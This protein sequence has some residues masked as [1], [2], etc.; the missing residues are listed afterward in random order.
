MI[1]VLTVALSGI[2]SLLLPG[3][4]TAHSRF[5]IPLCID[6][7]STCK[8]RKGSSLAAL[9]SQAAL[10]VWDKVP[11]NDKASFDALD[12]SLSDLSPQ[13]QSSQ[14]RAL[15][16]VNLSYWVGTFGKYCLLSHKEGIVHASLSS[17]SLWKFFRV[18]TLKQNM[19]LS[20]DGLNDLEKATNL[21]MLESGYSSSCLAHL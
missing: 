20:S 9:I 6:E 3:G 17:S 21:C 15:L 10:I 14:Q 12:K 1:I 2:A 13:P 16:A 8:I 19:R 4:R 11:T 18:F 5:K 7:C